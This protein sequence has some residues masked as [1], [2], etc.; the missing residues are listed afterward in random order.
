MCPCEILKPYWTLSST[1]LSFHPCYKF[2]E[3]KTASPVKGITEMILLNVDIVHNS[4][5][6]FSTISSFYLNIHIE[7]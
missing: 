1:F 3:I 4:F 6:P 5:D 7:L 2:C